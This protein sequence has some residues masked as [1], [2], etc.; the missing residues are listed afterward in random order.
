MASPDSQQL[1]LLTSKLAS[2]LPPGEKFVSPCSIHLALALVAAGATGQTLAEMQAALNWPAGP[3]WQ[4]QL[5][6]LLSVLWTAAG[7]GEPTIAVA[8]RVFTKVP[9]FPQFAAAVQSTFG[10]TIEPLQSAAQ[11]NEFV[12]TATQR[13]ITQIV[14]DTQVD[15]SL[16]IAVN[17]LYFKGKWEVQLN[18][19]DTTVAPFTTRALPGSA[20]RVESCHLMRTPAGKEWRYY[21]DA[22]AQYVLMPYR[23]AGGAIAAVVALP[24]DAAA[25]PLQAADFGAALGRLRATPERKGT[26]WLP[27][28]AA[29]SEA[30][31][32]S[33]LSALG[34]RRAFA[35]GAEFGDV[36]AAPLKIS[37]VLHKVKVEV[38]EE[39][40]VA[41]AVTAVCCGFGGAAPSGPPP[42]QMRCDR[43]FA[44]AVAH[45]PSRLVLFAG[46]VENPGCVGDAPQPQPQPAAPGGAVPWGQIPARNPFGPPDASVPG[47]FAIAPAS[48]VPGPFATAPA[49]AFPPAPAPAAA[50]ASLSIEQRREQACL[51]TAACRRDV[52]RILCAAPRGALCAPAPQQPAAGFGFGGG[53]PPRA[54]TPPL[55]WV[56]SATPVT[57][58]FGGGGGDGAHGG[59]PQLV[60]AGTRTPV[61]DVA[62]TLAAIETVGQPTP[63]GVAFTEAFEALLVR[64][65]VGWW[66]DADAATL[67]TAFLAAFG[68]EL[69]PRLDLEHALRSRALPPADLAWLR[70]LP[71]AIA[72]NRGLIDTFQS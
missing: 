19:A 70:A 57:F 41:A 45:V 5:A 32:M 58:G 18:K 3:S 6:Q 11:V 14:N 64:E 62:R 49:S 16:L 29:E 63:E 39:G 12:S 68:N 66:S 25:D 8:N 72:F 31:L 35:D 43:P 2:V 71:P 69:S 47:P 36:S 17:A 24:K 59:R 7:A 15:Q 67:S 56:F 23:G 4:Q 60:P 27:R 26:L 53:A 21:E 38:D 37:A 10:A 9:V 65:Y 52:Y 46:S 13:M 28:F 40:T 42:F 34:V 48:A 50:S 33:G 51:F 30:N 55:C 61:E 20:S 22:A 1:S 44:F 54:A